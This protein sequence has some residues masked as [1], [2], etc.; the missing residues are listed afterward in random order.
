VTHR[1]AI[2][3]SDAIDEK[4]HPKVADSVLADRNTADPS[5]F[6]FSVDDAYSRQ[7]ASSSGGPAST[8]A[9]VPDRNILL[10]CK[11]LARSHGLSRASVWPFFGPPGLNLEV[12]RRPRPIHVAGRPIPP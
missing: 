5:G 6:T 3:L 11:N 1:A 2:H 9:V 12:S 10:P 8:Y 4:S 7:K